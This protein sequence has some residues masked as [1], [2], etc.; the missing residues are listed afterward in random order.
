MN[1]DEIIKTQQ[2]EI[3][4]KDKIIDEMAEKL[5]Y[6]EDLKLDVCIYCK[7]NCRI[8][9]NQGDYIKTECIKE[10]FINKAEKEN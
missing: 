9:R 1:K 5:S 3:E 6:V 10:Y 2:E 4:K 7:E 8:P